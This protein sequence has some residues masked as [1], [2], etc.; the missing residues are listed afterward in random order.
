MNRMTTF[1]MPVGYWDE[2]LFVAD[3]I[4]VDRARD[5]SKPKWGQEKER[6][7]GD[8]RTGVIGEFC[9]RWAYGMPMWDRS[10]YPPFKERNNG[11]VG[12]NCEVRGTFTATG[13]LLLHTD[14]DALPPFLTRDY[15][16]VVLGGEGRFRLPG[17]LPMPVA[18][19]E[20]FDFNPHGHRPCKAVRQG[21]LWPIMHLTIKENG[22]KYRMRP[23]L[24]GRKE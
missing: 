17:W 3:G 7:K 12:E 21:R 8:N 1:Q 6:T 4:Q 20:W 19:T 10:T 11:D 18:I 13:K 9:L 2:A 14:K 22:V 5:G 15:A 16:L 24:M 23:E